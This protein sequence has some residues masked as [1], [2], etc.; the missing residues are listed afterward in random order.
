MRRPLVADLHPA[1]WAVFVVSVAL[2]V[3]AF[4]STF[5]VSLVPF[6]PSPEPGSMLAVNY[7][8]YHYAAEAAIAGEDFYDAVPPGRGDGYVYLY[9]PITVLVYYPFTLVSPATGYLLHTALAVVGAGAV[10]TVAVVRY[11][12][13]FDIRLGWLDV[14]LIFGFFVVSVHASP[15]VYFGNVNLV[16]GAAFAV[17]FLLLAR[18]RAVAAGV[19]FGVAAL[20]KVFPALVGVWL[21][22]RRSWGAIFGA[23]ATGLGGLLLGAIVF[24]IDTTRT[25]FVDALFPRSSTPAFVGGLDPDE[26]YYVTVQR[27]LSHV[28]WTV[29]PEA[30]EEVLFP[31]ALLVLGLILASLYRDLDGPVDALV[32]IYATTV[33]TVILL[34]SLR[35]YVVLTFLPAI[36]LLYVWGWHPAGVPF[37]LGWLLAALAFRPSMAISRAETLPEPLFAIAEPLLTVAT[38]Q[39]WG[40]ALT[41]VACVAYKYRWADHDTPWTPPAWATA[42]GAEDG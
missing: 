17:G 41:M 32:A 34:P 5:G 21:L 28:I 13:T 2:G 3:R 4:A 7:E 19:A 16:L 10:A 15:T 33:V 18:D 11:V 37:T 8:V 14:A 35:M 36:T 30:P 26:T 39:L 9:P 22:R 38:F 6:D 24:G 42:R 29:W 27:P 1:A 23:T 12:E 31:A 20:F 40:L 25:F